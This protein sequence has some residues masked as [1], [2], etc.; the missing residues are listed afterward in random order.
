[1]GF[2]RFWSTFQNSSCLV[3]SLV[4]PQTPQTPKNKDAGKV[5]TYRP[6]FVFLLFLGFDLIFF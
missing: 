1:M 4:N 6:W 5:L 3:G 2:A